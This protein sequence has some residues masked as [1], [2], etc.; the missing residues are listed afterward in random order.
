MSSERGTLSMGTDPRRSSE[1]LVRPFQAAASPSSYSHRTRL[2]RGD[3]VA[4]NMAKSK[5]PKPSKSRPVSTSELNQPLL[6]SS[7]SVTA[8][9]ASC[10]FSPAPDHTLF[11]HISNQVHQQ[12]LRIYNASASAASSS[13]LVTDFLLA[14]LGG[15][16]CL[17]SRWVR[18]SSPTAKSAKRRKHGSDAS[19]DAAASGSS[20]LLLA[21][22]LSSGEVHL[23][24][25]ALAQSVAILDASSASGSS[26]ASSANAGIVSMSYSEA[27]KTLFACSKSGWVSSFALA[28]VKLGDQPSPLRPFSSFRP[29][30]KSAVQLLSSRRDL[31]LSAHHSISLT[32]ISQSDSTVR[33][34]FTGHASPVTHLEWLDDNSFVSAAEGDRMISAWTYDAKAAKAVTGRAFATAALDGPVRAL[35]VSTAA[36]QHQ[37]T[38]ITIVTQTGSVR[39]YGLPSE[40]KAEASPSKKKS[41]ALPSLELLAQSSTESSGA[42]V[43]WI[44]AR[45]VS[46][47]L[48]LARLIRG[49]KVSIEETTVISGKDA[50]LQKV[51]QLPVAGGKNNT[52]AGGLLA[53]DTD[54]AQLTGG[55][56]ET[57]RYADAPARPQ[58][59]E[60]AVLSAGLEDGGLVPSASA[61][62]TDVEPTLAQRLKELGFGDPSLAGQEA[63]EDD[64]DVPTKKQQSLMSEASL[65]SSLS[66]ALHSGDTSLLTSCLNHNDAILIRNTVRKISGPLAVKLLEECV[67]RLNGVG[68]HHV[69]KGSMGSQKAR[70]LMEWVRATLLNHMG[71]L[72]SLPNLVSRLSGLHATLSTRLATHE[73]LL[74][75]NGRLELVLSQIEARAAYVSQASNN[76]VRVQGVKFGKKTQGGAVQSAGVVDKE[77]RKGKKWVEESDDSESDMDVDGA[78]GVLVRGEDDEDGDVQDIALGAND[79]DD[80]DDDEDSD[81]DGPIRRRRRVKNGRMSDG[82]TSVDSEDDDDDEDED[83]DDV[84]DIEEDDDDD[85]EEDE[86]EEDDEEEL[87]DESDIEEEGASDMEDDEEEEEYD[88]EDAK[89]P[90]GMFDLEAEEGTD[91]D[92]EE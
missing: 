22:G 36:D 87:P 77:R 43:E 12:R 20:Q 89:G 44:D 5:A 59:V 61:R 69:S 68:G 73:R 27:K 7:G 82:N 72:M 54:E 70:G 66:Q 15:A 30:T 24:S 67:N 83:E 90:N 92:D 9:T 17:S 74:A 57:Q 6:P 10:S 79:S 48:R 11:A 52:S 86:E 46:D 23:L 41:A 1:V 35:S 49:A 84:E 32:D 8:S 78:D 18:L 14:S 65:A 62:G 53:A 39:I 51:L 40:S 71:Y 56:A 29:D 47:K 3:K 16:E 81:D 50:H 88:E 91:E 13:Q 76:A 45:L 28:D 31:I 26:T 64:A 34:T 19:E 2:D 38:L 85:E 75:L 80:E 63:D 60:D 33:A 37:R 42:S 25:P 58:D 21:L 4:A 55:A